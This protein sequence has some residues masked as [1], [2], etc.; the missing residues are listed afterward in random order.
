ML[1]KSYLTRWHILFF[2]Y[3]LLACKGFMWLANSFVGK[4]LLQ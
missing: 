1:S 4:S 3:R 2:Y